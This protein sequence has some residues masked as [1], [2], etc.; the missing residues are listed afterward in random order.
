ML[1]E[2]AAAKRVLDDKSLKTLDA[3]AFIKGQPQDAVLA[4]AR[5]LAGRHDNRAV[6]DTLNLTGQVL[7][8]VYADE[9]ILMVDP[10]DHNHVIIPV[11]EPFVSPST[12]VLREVKNGV[13]VNSVVALTNFD[14]YSLEA[15]A[16]DPFYGIVYLAIYAGVNDLGGTLMN[17]S[18]SRA[19]GASHGQELP[20][21]DGLVE[22][23]GVERRAHL[24]L[25]A[26]TVVLEGL[27]ELVSGDFL[28]VDQRDGVGG[29]GGEVRTDT[30]KG[31]G[32]DQ[33]AEDE[34]GDDAIQTISN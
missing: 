2:T 23:F 11:H 21:H 17:E 6:F 25:Q 20:P 8:P 12:L 3:R 31:E 5:V 14:G 13:V 32:N 28:V 27:V 30:D 7:D 10:R 34:N 19:A 26:A 33:K 15:A 24:R 1:P 22:Q 18:I 29:P 4:R 16:Y 9:D